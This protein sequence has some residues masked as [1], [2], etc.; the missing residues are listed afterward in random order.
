MK[1]PHYVDGV[2]AGSAPIFGVYGLTPASDPYAFA[3]TMT[4]DAST[5]VGVDSDLCVSNIQKGWSDIGTMAD[6]KEGREFLSNAF[7]LC[8]TATNSYEAMLTMDIVDESISYMAMSSYPYASN[9]IAGAVLG[10]ETG[11]LPAYPIKSACN[12][13]LV[14]EFETAEDRITAIASFNAVF[15]NSDGE[16]SC[17]DTSTMW[18]TYAD[19]IWVCSFPSAMFEQVQVKMTS[20]LVS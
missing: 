12:E 4:Y 6:T 9:Y 2:I 20:F 10:T 3:K 16:G 19:Y 18:D 14:E 1:Y 15:W 13:Y 5:L 8:N 7:N 11:S 17:L